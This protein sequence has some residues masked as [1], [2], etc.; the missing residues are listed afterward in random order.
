MENNHFNCPL[1][2]KSQLAYK[3]MRYKVLLVV[4]SDSLISMKGISI[5]ALLEKF[6]PFLIIDANSPH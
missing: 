4:L 6:L 1:I 2:E 5:T 3:I